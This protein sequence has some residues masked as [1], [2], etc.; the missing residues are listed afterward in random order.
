V[1]NRIICAADD[2]AESLS[3]DAGGTVKRDVVALE[4]VDVLAGGLVGELDGLHLAGDRR[5]LEANAIASDD[6]DIG[7]HLIADTHED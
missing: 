2:D 3:V 6:T 4:D 5:H 7:G 1:T